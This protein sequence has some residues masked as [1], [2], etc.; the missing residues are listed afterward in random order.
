[1]KSTTELYPSLTHQVTLEGRDA[2]AAV[3]FTQAI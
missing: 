2:S 1:V 3:P